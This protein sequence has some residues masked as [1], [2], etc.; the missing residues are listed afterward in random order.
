ML[1]GSAAIAVSRASRASRGLPPSPLRRLL[2]PAPSEAEPPLLLR[3]VEALVERD[4]R[5]TTAKRYY[6]SSARLDAATFAHAMRAHWGIENRLHWVL[7]VVFRD[8]HARLRTGHGP[9]NMATVRH[10]ALNVLRDAPGR[11]S[12]KVRRKKAGWN[13]A[14]LE[15]VV[16]QTR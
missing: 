12:L 9:A 8:D 2:A 13:T 1:P 16:R 11:H 15:V 14:Y 4:G 3:L 10:M 6:L 7:D 5:A